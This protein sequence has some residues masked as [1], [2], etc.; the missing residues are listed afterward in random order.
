M[1]SQTR[2]NIEKRPIPFDSASPNCVKNPPSPC[3]SL[4]EKL[5]SKF[6]QNLYYNAIE[7]H[8]KI[9]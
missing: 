2:P 5:R 8:T 4:T 3:P 1:S 7:L 6:E 9:Q